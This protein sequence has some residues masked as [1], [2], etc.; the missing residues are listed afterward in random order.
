MTFHG[1]HWALGSHCRLL[2]IP[3]VLLSFVPEMREWG[4]GQWHQPFIEPHR[5][6]RGGWVE[7]PRQLWQWCWRVAERPGGARINHRPLQP[8]DRMYRVEVM[9]HNYLLTSP[10]L[11]QHVSV[12]A[13]SVWVQSSDR[14]FVWHLRWRESMKCQKCGHVS[15]GALLRKQWDFD[16]KRLATP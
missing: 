14:L 15:P 5:G 6:G 16:N 9:G 12:W 3:S 11:H 2:L 1:F 10:T 8:R 4:I 7:Q 13:A